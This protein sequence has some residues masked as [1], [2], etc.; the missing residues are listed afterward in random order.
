MYFC[1]LEKSNVCSADK[2]FLALIKNIWLF[3]GKV[4]GNCIVVMQSRARLRLPRCLLFGTFQWEA[5]VSPRS[6]STGLAVLPSLLWIMEIKECP[7]IPRRYSYP[8]GVQS[9][10][11]VGKACIA[12][13]QWDR[14]P[15]ST[16]LHCSLQ[17]LSWSF[18]GGVG[19]VPA[20][21]SLALEALWSQGN[22]VC[23]SALR[24]FFSL[25]LA[26]NQEKDVKWR[27]SLR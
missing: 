18:G 11:C 10:G 20:R 24:G 3:H 6:V 8:L 27:E 15:A 2:S 23:Y 1:V 26:P 5:E 16:T 4:L 17:L 25:P 12:A 21:W 22:P 14:N 19:F 9:T 13:V 7:G